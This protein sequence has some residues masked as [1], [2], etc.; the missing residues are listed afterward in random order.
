[1]PELPEVH[2]TVTH[3]Q[4]LITKLN[5]TDI[6]TNY[7]SPHYRGK[8]QIKDPV[9]FKQF[10]KGVIGTKVVSV[11]RRGKNILIH[12]NN[13]KTI[14]V[15]MKMTGHFLYGRYEYNLKENEWRAATGSGPLTDP[16]NGW[17][18]LVFSFS[19]GNHL[20]LSDLRKFAK[21]TLL[22]TSEVF[23]SSDLQKIGPEIFEN[24]T[25]LK[26]FTQRLQKKPKMKIKTALMNQE[27]VAGIGNIYSD[28]ALFLA[29]IRPDRMVQTLSSDEFKKLLPAA[30]KVLKKGINFG[31]DSTSD[32]R[33]PDGLP[34]EFHLNHNVYRETGKPCKTK[35]C[36]G[37][38]KREVINGRSAH[39]CDRCQG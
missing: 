30:R 31:G 6:W 25:T 35:Q 3:L 12:L 32:Y 36:P 4:K 17:I 10:K 9:Y 24:N 22:E 39:F 27:L 37:I 34:G 11:E 16:F 8:K 33:K 38:V 13:E 21:V 5:I 28:E 2:T 29:H 14:L 23:E 19:N 15:H 26:Q 1:M 18:R 20:T 7:N